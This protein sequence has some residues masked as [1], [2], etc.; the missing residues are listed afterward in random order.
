MNIF[1]RDTYLLKLCPIPESIQQCIFN[2][3]I[4]FGT[5]STNAIKTTPLQLEN[6]IP[7]KVVALGTLDRCR[8]TLY[9]MERTITHWYDNSNY[10]SKEALFGLHQIYLSNKKQ[11]AY[12]TTKTQDLTNCLQTMSRRR[13]IQIVEEELRIKK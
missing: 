13:L 1:E 5:P 3:L 10:F 6:E 11:T 4:G 2:L 9:Y 12:T 8:Y 7:I